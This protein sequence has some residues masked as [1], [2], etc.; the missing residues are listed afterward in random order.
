MKESWT[1]NQKEED[2]DRNSNKQKKNLTEPSLI[3]S[4]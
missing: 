2:D 3:R 1:D 4:N